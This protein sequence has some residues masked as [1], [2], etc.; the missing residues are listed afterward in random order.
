[1]LIA[2]GGGTTARHQ[3]RA[4]RRSGCAGVGPMTPERFF[5]FLCGAGTTQVS[6]VAAIWYSP[7]SALGKP[8][9]VWL[10]RSMKSSA[11]MPA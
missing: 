2:G 8:V 5:C 9:K 1:M 11:R 7:A 4:P 10:D 6:V 3:F